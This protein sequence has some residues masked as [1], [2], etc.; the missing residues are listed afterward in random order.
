MMSSDLTP[1][2][3]EK[4]TGLDAV[5]S[6]YFGHEVIYARPARHEPC[7]LQYSTTAVCG[8]DA[9]TDMATLLAEIERL[10]KRLDNAATE[11]EIRRNALRSLQ[12]LISAARALRNPNARSI[13]AAL[14]NYTAWNVVQPILDA[15]D[16]YDG[17]KKSR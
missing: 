16:D 4:P 1:S 5:K 13:S 14:G 8:C 3:E 15:V 6:R 10:Q 9:E 17:V 2:A 12:P 11:S 7:W